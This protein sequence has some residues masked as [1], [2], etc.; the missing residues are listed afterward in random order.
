[1]ALPGGSAT[2]NRTGPLIKFDGSFLD[3]AITVGARAAI[4]KTVEDE[5]FHEYTYTHDDPG[6]GEAMFDTTSIF[7]KPDFLEAVFGASVDIAKF[8]PVV[9]PALVI[10]G[11]YGMYNATYGDFGASE[12]A[13]LSASLNYQFHQ[14]FNVLFGYQQLTTNLK[15]EKDFDLGTLTFDNLAFGLGY[16]VADGGN[17]TAKVTWV[18]GDGNDRYFQMRDGD[19]E[20]RG[21]GYKAMQPE[22]YLTVRF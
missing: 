21:K 22:I 13:L 15:G 2:A 5:A 8:V 14:R 18:S 12:S 1:M 10:G 7:F 4:V 17:I 9:G 6:T 19:E 16:R 20:S 11:S 3:K